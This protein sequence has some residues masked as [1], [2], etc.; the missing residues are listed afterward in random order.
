[1]NPE[2]AEQ[3]QRDIAQRVIVTDQLADTIRLIAG[4][5]V[6]YG[7]EGDTRVYAGIVLIDAV[8]LKTVEQVTAVQ[9]SAFEYIPGLFA[10]RELPAVLEAFGKLTQRPDLVI[11]DGQGRAHPRRCGLACHFGVTVDLP[12]IG[13]GKTRF[14]G[15]FEAVEEARGSSRPL[16]DA[17]E[18]IGNV[19]RTQ[20]GVKPLFVSIGHR[21]SLETATNWILRLAPEYRQPEPIRRAN[22]LVNQ[23][24]REVSQS[25]ILDR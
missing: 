19:L 3:I 9:E 23:I 20:A 14:I 24:R 11:S 7:K 1:M 21:I 25:E 8:T 22:E 12:T 2:H 17:S 6:A 15:E 16:M 10:F 13:C 4:V 18:Q 5:D